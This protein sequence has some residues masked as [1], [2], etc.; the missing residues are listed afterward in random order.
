MRHQVRGRT[1]GRKTNHRRAMWR[2]MTVSLFTHGQITTTLPK[3]KSLVPFVERLITAAKRGDLHAR[4]QVLSALGGDRLL[5][6]GDDDENI[7]R[8][9]YGEITEQTRVGSP[10]VVRHLFEDIAPRYA[11]RDGGYTRI[12]R[13]ARHRI[14]DATDLVVLQLVGENESRPKPGTSSQRRRTADNRTA[15]AAKL[16]K[17]GSSSGVSSPSAAVS[18]AV[19]DSDSQTQ[20]DPINQG[21]ASGDVTQSAEEGRSEQPPASTSAPADEGAPS[22]GEASS[23]DTAAEGGKE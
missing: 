12:I 6:R 7:R 5:I 2:N 18:A 22:P 9:R 1:L 14:G 16:R 15:Y 19:S 17:A 11:D 4:R 13:L 3:A 21:G 10:R 20:E 23:D 8:N